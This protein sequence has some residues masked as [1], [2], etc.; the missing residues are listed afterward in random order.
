MA[1]VL[2]STYRFTVTHSQDSNVKAEKI[3]RR[4]VETVEDR[5]WFQLIDGGQITRSNYPAHGKLNG[6]TDVTPILVGVYSSDI[7]ELTTDEVK[8]YKLPDCGALIKVRE[9]T[10]SY[11]GNY[12][13]GVD[14][15][16]LLPKL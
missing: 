16:E 2:E 15:L 5:S 6:N 13:A 10:S 1:L 8:L 7:Q 3:V 9:W 12:G 14:V 4:H 11:N